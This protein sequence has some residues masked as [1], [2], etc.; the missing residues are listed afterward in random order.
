MKVELL[1]NGDAELWDFF[2]ACPQSVAQE[3]PGVVGRAWP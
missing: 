3:T 2:E 1:R